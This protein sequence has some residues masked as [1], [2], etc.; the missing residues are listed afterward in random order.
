M[1]HI[2][3]L[4]PQDDNFTQ[5]YAGFKLQ[6]IDC[7]GGN[8]PVA[9]HNGG[10]PRRFIDP[11]HQPAAEESAIAVDVRGTDGF[12]RLNDGLPRR[13][14]SLFKFLLF[15]FHTA[16]FFP[17]AAHIRRHPAF[18]ILVSLSADLPAGVASRVVFCDDQLIVDFLLK[19]RHMRDNTDH[20]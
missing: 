11:F 8:H 1:S 15:F 17:R 5:A 4:C 19:F 9:V 7:C 2:G 6:V 14:V 13:F 12:D 18:R 16:P 10:Q 20:P 3:D